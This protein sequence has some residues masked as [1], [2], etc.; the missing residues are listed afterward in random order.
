MNCDLPQPV[1]ASKRACSPSL[2]IKSNDTVGIEQC[3]QGSS[4]KVGADDLVG[5]SFVIYG[6]YN[7]LTFFGGEDI[8]VELVTKRS[9]KV[10]VEHLGC[11][12]RECNVV[13]NLSDVREYVDEGNGVAAGGW[14]TRLSE[15]AVRRKVLFEYGKT[16]GECLVDK[17]ECL[18]GV[19]SLASAGK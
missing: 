16:L 15:S 8:V 12:E 11:E 19:G 7:I 5:R 10:C 14:V 4:G 3:L 13:N 9:E 18:R 6:A 2:S 17:V 1:A